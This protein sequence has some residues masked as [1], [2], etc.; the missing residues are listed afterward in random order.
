MGGDQD[1]GSGEKE[2]RYARKST[3]DPTVSQRESAKARA[4]AQKLGLGFEMRRT[5]YGE[6][7]DFVARAAAR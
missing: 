3:S 4:A 1:D 5:G 2:R 7:A 6:L